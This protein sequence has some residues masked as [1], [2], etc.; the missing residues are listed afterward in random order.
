VWVVKFQF[1]GD[2]V[3]HVDE[4]VDVGEAPC[5]AFGELDFGIDAFEQPVV[6]SAEF[7][8]GDNAVPMLS[9]GL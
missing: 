2:E 6:E 3:D 9:D 8:V 1:A 7:E 5:A 4:V